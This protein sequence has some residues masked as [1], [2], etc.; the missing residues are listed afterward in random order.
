[1]LLLQVAAKRA[2]WAIAAACLWAIIAAP[3]VAW[4]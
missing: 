2:V 3:L 1:M 4:A